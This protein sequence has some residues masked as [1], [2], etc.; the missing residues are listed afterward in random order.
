MFAVLDIPSVGIRGKIIEGTDDT[1]LKNYIGM[2]KGSSLPGSYGNFCIAAHNNIYTEI[3]RNLHNV[4]VDDKVR[5]ITK[6]YEYVYIVKSIDEIAPTQTEVL[7]QDYSKKEIT[8]I[9]C[10]DLGRTRIVVKGILMSQIEI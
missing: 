6:N 5:V 2:F 10:T 4:K 3:F 1:T 7:D 9:T 8:L